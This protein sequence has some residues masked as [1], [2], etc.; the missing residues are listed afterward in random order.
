M[1]YKYTITLAAAILAVAIPALFLSQSSKFAPRSPAGLNATWGKR[2]LVIGLDDAFP[3]IGF[4]DESGVLTG[5]DVELAREACRRI[6]LKP[7]FKPVVWDSVILSL[8]NGDIDVIWNGMTITDSRKKQIAFSDPYLKGE[9]VFLS[10]MDSNLKSKKD[11]AG[12]VIAV[13]AGSEQEETVRRDENALK[14]REIRT[15]DT[16][17]AALLDM[18]TGRIDAVLVDNFSG[19]YTAKLVF[20]PDY[21]P[22]QF[23][24]DYGATASGVGMRKRDGFLTDEINRALAEMKRDGTASR[25]AEKWFGNDGLLVK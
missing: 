19:L 5:F 4:R 13:Q 23:S 20:G 14:P 3:P 16:V 24:G 9:N 2:E 6:G 17:Q 11:L 21:K 18:K 22:R 25:I 15:Y 10:G 12:K 8:N 7:V 1:K